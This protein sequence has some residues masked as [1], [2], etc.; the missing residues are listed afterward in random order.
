MIVQS[1][2]YQALIPYFA[3]AA[4]Y[5]VI[6]MFLTWVMGKLERRL[7]QVIYVKGLSKSFG[8]NQVIKIL[9]CILLRERKWLL[10]DRPVLVNP[11]FCSV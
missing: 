5:L 9:I 4:I 3:I 11:H 6:V 2:T 1:K 10:S 8:D 7:R